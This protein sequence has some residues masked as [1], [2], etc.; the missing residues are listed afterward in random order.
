[1]IELVDVDRVLAEWNRLDGDANRLADEYCLLV[2]ERDGPNQP[3]PAIRQWLEDRAERIRAVDLRAVLQ[4]IRHDLEGTQVAPT[5]VSA[6][7][8]FDPESVTENLTV[9]EGA[10]RLKQQRKSQ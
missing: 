3:V 2:R 4:I 9:R 5:A 8:L 1:M 6:P 7:Q 10:Q